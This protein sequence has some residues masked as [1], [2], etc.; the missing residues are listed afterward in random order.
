MSNGGVLARSSRG[1][2]RRAV[3]VSAIGLFVAS[4]ST[5]PSTSGGPG[6]IE[7][8][9]ATSPADTSQPGSATGGTE[10]SEAPP[11]T[12]ATTAPE[13]TPAT[14]RA[15][16]TAS[17]STTVRTSTTASDESESAT[18]N[19][20]EADD[21]EEEE[22][23]KSESAT[24][25]ASTKASTT[26]APSTTEAPSTAA[27][28][29]PAGRPFAAV[30]SKSGKETARIQQ[31]L[32]DLGFWLNGVDG[33]YGITT[34]QAV[35]AFQKYH[36]LK[37]TATVD[38]ATAKALSTATSRAHGRGGGTG[39][40]IDKDRQVLFINR[41]GRMLWALNTS[42]GSGQYF[43]ERNQKDPAKFEAGRSVTPSGQFR[44]NRQRPT[45]WWD[46]DLG[47]IYRP[48]YFNGGIAVHGMTNIPAYPASHGCVRLSVPAMDMVW[49]LG[50]I[51]MGTSVVVY[52]SDIAPKNKKPTIPDTEPPS[53]SAPPS[54]AKPNPS[55]TKPSG[56]SSTRPR[57]TKPPTTTP[58]TTPTTA[59]TTPTTPAPTVPQTPPTTPA[60]TA[61]PTP[62]PT[63]PPTTPAPPPS[64]DT[65][66][67]P[68]PST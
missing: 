68:A 16:S 55:T 5:D 40:E 43:L 66:V 3:W 29:R 4:C 12:T 58:S 41:G 67:P 42:T 14:S 19:D 33:S 13:T 63:E 18:T 9:P 62:A 45:G 10:A 22:P 46:G 26:D 15:A 6:S 52:G 27:E 50:F 64:S 1:A 25:T 47:K 61:S 57:T 34:R 56:P 35:L 23:D 59:P 21:T 54:T 30:G 17:P 24:T 51:G 53:T 44:I 49:D 20:S 37:R 11:S 2:V 48:K 32:L 39:I 31:R 38:K 60:P 7:T 28:P 8:E 65:T 36:G